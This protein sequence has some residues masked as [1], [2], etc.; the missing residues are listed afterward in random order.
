M[1]GDACEGSGSLFIFLSNSNK[2]IEDNGSPFNFLSDSKNF[3][4]E[5]LTFFKS[6]LSKSSKAL[7]ST[8]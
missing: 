4:Y 5:H 7:D 2:S 8:I 6:Q 1:V 3:V